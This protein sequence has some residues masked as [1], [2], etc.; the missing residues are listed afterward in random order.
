MVVSLTQPCYHLDQLIGA[1]GVDLHLAD[2]V[3]DVVYF[4]QPGGRSHALLVDVRS[5][6]LFHTAFPTLNVVVAYFSH[7]DLHSNHCHRF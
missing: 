5:N 1:V 7:A 4:Q 3:E 2:L 6:A